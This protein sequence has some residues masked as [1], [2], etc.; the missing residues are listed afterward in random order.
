MKVA[1]Y[2]RVS[3]QRQEI[4]ETIETQI[5]GIKDFIKLNNHILI[6]EYRDD[7]WSGTILAR[8]ALD[9]LRLDAPKRLFEAVV[10]YDPDRL[11]RKYAHQELVIDELQSRGVEFYS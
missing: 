6:Q 8:P 5:M 3:S 2:A 9:Q 7:G 1:F 10:V 11:S 4:E